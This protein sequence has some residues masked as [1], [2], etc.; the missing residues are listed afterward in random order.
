VSAIQE[1]HDIVPVKRSFEVRSTGCMGDILVTSVRV[2]QR[3][4]G[5]VRRGG[6]GT[7]RQHSKYPFP[8]SMPREG[9]KTKVLPGKVYGHLCGKY[10]SKL[11]LP[12]PMPRRPV[13]TGYTTHQH[14]G[15]HFQESSPRHLPQ[16]D[17]GA[18]DH[19]RDQPCARR[20][21]P[22]TATS[23]TFPAPSAYPAARSRSPGTRR[24]TQCPVPCTT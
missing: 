22:A 6:L 2:D 21:A 20:Y 14:Q 12:L 23:A 1:A 24:A 17:A 3:C 8:N 9:S 7:E 19:A 15:Q 5:G 4:A 16:S 11:L 10:Y 18:A 13:I